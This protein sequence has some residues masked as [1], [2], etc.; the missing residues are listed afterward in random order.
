VTNDKMGGMGPTQ[1]H[2]RFVI[3]PTAI[4]LTHDILL[5]D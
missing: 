5:V 3:K 4:T 1:L 2:R